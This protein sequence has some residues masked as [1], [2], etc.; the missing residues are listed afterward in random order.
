M[1]DLGKTA[2]IL[3]H[4]LG[5]SESKTAL[6]GGSLIASTMHSRISGQAN[7]TFPEKT[8]H[9]STSNIDPSA[10]A[11][12]NNLLTESMISGNSWKTIGGK[13]D[14]RRKRAAEQSVLSEQIPGYKGLQEVDWL[15]N[16]IEVS[17]FVLRIVNTWCI[18][19]FII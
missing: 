2:K 6:K 10:V 12:S 11:N 18:Q 9:Q 13:R 14:K 15:V 1:E 7:P 4:R 19:E 3:E 17:I 8:A 16:F 5:M